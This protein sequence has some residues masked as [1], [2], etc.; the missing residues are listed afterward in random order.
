[1]IWPRFAFHDRLAPIDGLFCE[2]Q[3]VRWGSTRNVV[4][5][6]WLYLKLYSS[7]S[8]FFFSPLHSTTIRLRTGSNDDELSKTYCASLPWGELSEKKQKIQCE[9]VTTSQGDDTCVEISCNGEPA[10]Q[11]REDFRKGSPVQ[12]RGHK[13]SMLT[14]LHLLLLKLLFVMKKYWWHHFFGAISTNVGLSIGW[15][16]ISDGHLYSTMQHSYK[17]KV[18]IRLKWKISLPF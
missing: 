4:W 9:A 5:R 11:W 16:F 6:R 18:K 3:K 7:I 10:K 14:S 2:E 8:K 13:R 1:M 17:L 12:G 15:Q